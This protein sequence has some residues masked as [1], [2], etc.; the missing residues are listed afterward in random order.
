[1]VY[2]HYI[3]IDQKELFKHVRIFVDINYGIFALHCDR[4]KRI[5]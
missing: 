5:I 1:M 3:V 2:L 4:S